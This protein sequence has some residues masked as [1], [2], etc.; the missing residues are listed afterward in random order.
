MMGGLSRRD[1]RA[2][3]AGRRTVQKGLRGT[4]LVD[5]VAGVGAAEK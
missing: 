2:V 3:A 5:H 1:I 4:L